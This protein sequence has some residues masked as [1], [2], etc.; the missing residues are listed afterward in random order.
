MIQPKR[1]ERR[2]GDNSS[3]NFVYA[4]ELACESLSN[5][6]ARLGADFSFNPLG[7]FEFAPRKG[8]SAKFSSSLTYQGRQ[9]GGGK[10]ETLLFMPED[11]TGNDKDFKFAELPAKW[12]PR[13]K[14]GVAELFI[15]AGTG[16]YDVWLQQVT[17]L[18]ALGLGSPPLYKWLG[19]EPGQYATLLNDTFF[20]E[21]P[22]PQQRVF[23]FTFDK[24]GNQHYGD[25]HAIIWDSVK[26]TSAGTLSL[27][28]FKNTWFQIASFLSFPE[29]TAELEIIRERMKKIDEARSSRQAR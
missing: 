13:K 17:S 19:V 1:L 7:V 25:P 15:A 11:G 22:L 8:Y 27:Q 21:R 5:S 12:T 2:I 18:G 9:V 3:L 4:T 29:D 23:D 16:Y 26:H 24:T 10:V 14:E 20:E 6:V 28:A